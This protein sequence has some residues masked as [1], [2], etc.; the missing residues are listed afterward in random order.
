MRV[1]FFISLSFVLWCSSCRSSSAINQVCFSKGCVEVEIVQKPEELMRGLQFR[2]TLASN[3][4]MLFIFPG[5]NIYSFWMKDTKIP[6]DMIWIDHS[7]RVIYIKRNVPPCAQ[8]PCPV[9]TPD[10]NARYVLE[11]NRNDV[12]RFGIHINTVA[13]FKLSH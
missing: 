5:E 9:Y 3:A 6:L 8:D 12:D 1:R 7:R 13:N 4:G 11:I 10:G 2:G